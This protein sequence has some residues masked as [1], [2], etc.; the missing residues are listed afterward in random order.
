MKRLSK[1]LMALTGALLLTFAGKTTVQAAEAPAPFTADQLL[2]A[3]NVQCANVSSLQQVLAENVLMTE[4]STGMTISVNMVMDVQQSRTVSHSTTSM[5][6]SMLG[7]SQGAVTE[8]YSM[9]SG[10]TLYSYTADASGAWKGTCKALTPAQAAS[11][12]SSFDV[13]GIDMT[14]AT[15]TVDGNLYRVRGVMDAASMEEFADMLETSGIVPSGAFPVVLDID[16]ATLLPVSLTVAMQNMSMSSMPG[17]T[18]AVNVVVTYGGYDQ[19][20]ALTVPA[21]VIANAA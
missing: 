9:I 20:D 16:A 8:N 7:I 10:S 5:V 14:T 1:C 4:A 3:V 6:M 15:V 11:Y 17:V 12:G 18:A 19:Y 21:S 2:G 13:N